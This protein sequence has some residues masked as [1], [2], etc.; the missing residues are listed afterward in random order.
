MFTL[1]VLLVL[2]DVNDHQAA[3]KELTKTSLIN[4][5]TML[6]AWTAEE[7][8]KYVETYKSFEH[9]PPD[10]IKERVAEDFLSQA[11]NVL[12]QVRG[13]NKTDVVTLLTR[14]GSVK[15]VVRAEREELGMCP[16]FGEVKAKRLRDTF[17][18]PFRVGEGRTFKQ[19]KTTTAS[20]TSNLTSTSTTTATTT[21]GATT[22]TEGGGLEDTLLTTNTSTTTTPTTTTSTAPSAAT[23]PTRALDALENALDDD[24]AEQEQLR[25]ALQLSMNPD[26]PSP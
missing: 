8:G 26:E 10:A 15:G 7:A 2:C 14:F 25:L 3:I 5:L 6:V 24:D 18:Q 4:G 16:G 17:N 20:T 22:N 12:T 9:R 19:R 1:R 13:V 23:A 21:R 11:T